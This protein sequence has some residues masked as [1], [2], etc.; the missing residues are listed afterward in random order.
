MLA[1]RLTTILPAMSLADALETMTGI[2]AVQALSTLGGTNFIDAPRMLN[3]L[4]DLETGEA[5]PHDMLR[6]LS[7]IRSGYSN[8]DVNLENL[9]KT[10][11]KSDATVASAH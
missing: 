8:V 9:L 6:I 10:L 7:Q 2:R 11:P 3:T 4:S 1:R 5:T